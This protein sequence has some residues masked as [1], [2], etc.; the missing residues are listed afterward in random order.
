MT[1]M[2]VTRLRQLK[3]SEKLKFEILC[4]A[5]GGDEI[6]QQIPGVDSLTEHFHHR[7][8]V[9]GVISGVG[10]GDDVISGVV[11][12]VVPQLRAVI[13]LADEVI[14]VTGLEEFPLQIPAG[15]A[16][17]YQLVIKGEYALELGVGHIT[18]RQ[19][20]GRAE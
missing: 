13:A 19:I 12:D 11:V 6:C 2:V 4:K 1:V 17:Q 8:I 14:T 5:A 18:L 16:A 10:V 3:R 9:G 7:Q 20:A 15:D